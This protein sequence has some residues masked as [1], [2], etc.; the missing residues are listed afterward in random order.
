MRNASNAFATRSAASVTVC[1]LGFYELYLNGELKETVYRLSCTF[2]VPT[3]ETLT[4]SFSRAAEGRDYTVK[5]YAVN[6]WAKDSEPLVG[7]VTI[8]KF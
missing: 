4:V 7:T 5:I 8:P 3:P 6:S 1:G 2:F